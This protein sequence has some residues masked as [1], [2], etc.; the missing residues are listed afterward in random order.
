MG[1]L[2]QTEREYYSSLDLGSY[3]FI[4][5]EHIINNFMV[6]YVG[7]GKIIPK[8]KRTD[9]LFH[10]QRSIQELSYDT[11]K[12]IKSQ[13]IELPPHLTMPLPHDYV[14]Y[15]KLVWSDSSG[16]EHIIYPTS[17]TS[18]PS[19]IIQQASGG[20]DFGPVAGDELIV[21]NDFSSPFGLPWTHSNIHPS[22]PTPVDTI[23]VVSGQLAIGTNPFA[24]QTNFPG[25]AYAVWQP[26]DVTGIDY[27]SI[28]ASGTSAPAE[29]GKSQDGLLRFGISS[30]PG[31]NGTNPYNN[32]NP[33]QNVNE[34]DIAS[35]EWNDGLGT[36][37]DQEL[38]DVDVRTYNTVYA[39]ITSRTVFTDVTAATS[40]NYIDNISVK[41]QT[42]LD[43]LQTGTST[44]WD[45]YRGND[46][47]ETQ[48]NYEDDTYWP[49]LGNRRGL[50]PVHA[51]GNGSF[52]ID[53]LKGKIHFSS[54]ISGKNIILK[55]ISDGLGTDA[56]M[57][58]H[59]FAEE[60]MYKSIAYAI[61]STTIAGQSLAP[62]F[63][64]QK[65][66]AIRTAKLRLS[67]LK[68]EELT[69]IM[70]GKSKFIKH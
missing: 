26:I 67:N 3:Q 36:S 50:D 39:L 14:N 38:I 23:G 33:S 49:N 1:L 19:K 62:S 25:R 16:I 10:A 29:A 65:S 31:D 69:Q 44:M 24:F 15:V 43:N 66:V 53:E 12:S 54:N 17:K 45:N 5:L 60:A 55:Y 11:L 68:I 13:E 42:T 9:V 27:L 20:Y 2:K 32:Q 48:N 18:N 22:N 52:Y 35:L 6:S 56:E 40:T 64:Q 57:V 47:L 34:P 37:S 70:R 28:S 59:K 63:Q 58:V 51:Q 8:V 7:E 4:S 30:A 46:P 61:L 21:N 41:S